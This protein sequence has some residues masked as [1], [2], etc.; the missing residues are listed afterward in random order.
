MAASLCLAGASVART[1]CC[2]ASFLSSTRLPVTSSMSAGEKVHPKRESSLHAGE[3]NLA[4]LEAVDDVVQPFLRGYDQPK[5]APVLLDRLRQT[6]EIEHA[7]D[8]A[9]H[10]LAD[11]VDH[12]DE[13]R[14][15]V[16]A[17]SNEFLRPHRKPVGIDLGL[18]RLRAHESTSGYVS[19]RSRCK[20]WLA[21]PLRAPRFGAR[22]TSVP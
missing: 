4:A 10:V 2:P 9:G 8:A 17:T 1:A 18:R 21:S 5:L 19:G 12:E 16:T 3:F 11:L 15:P 14:G 22:P 20:A 7:I 6:L 13:P